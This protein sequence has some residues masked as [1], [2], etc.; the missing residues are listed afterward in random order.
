LARIDLERDTINASGARLVG[1]SVLDGLGSFCLVFA[2]RVA[3]FFGA[4]RW[5]EME[6]VMHGPVGKMTDT[7]QRLRRDMEQAAA[8]AMATL[9]LVARGELRFTSDHELRACV[10]LARMTRLFI[11][12]L[13]AP[14]P[15]LGHPDNAPEENRR[16]LEMLEAS[17]SRGESANS[18]V[19]PYW[20][21]IVAEDANS[22]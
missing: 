3:R 4:R 11:V 2:A 6:V 1:L 13:E 10:A 14:A 16:L 19:E 7:Q 12:K 22:K 5:P 21:D 15:S 18:R 8:D 17:R 20:L 9:R